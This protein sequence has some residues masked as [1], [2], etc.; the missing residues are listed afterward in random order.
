[1]NR[2]AITCNQRGFTLLEI[3][4]VLGIMVMLAGML[5]PA[6]GLMNE[7]ERERITRARMEEIRRAIVGD[8][9]RVDENGRRIIGGYVGD[10]KTWPDLYEAAPEKRQNV[11][12]TP[13]FD[14]NDPN[15]PTY[16][17]YRPSGRF[18][19]KNWRWNFPYH[20]LTDD[21]IYNNDHIGGLVTENEGQPVGL[22]SDNPK[23]DGTEM[24][25]H[26]RWQ[27]PYL[28]PPADNKPEDSLHL[29]ESNGDY[30][31][32]EPKYDP[33]LSA[34][35][36]E[37]G[38][39]SPYDFD[40]GEHFDEKEDFRLRQT[41]ERLADGW[42][43][44]FRFYITADPARPGET[45]FW[46]VSEGADSEGTYPTKGN[47]GATGWTGDANDTM[48][49]NYDPGDEYNRDNLVMK[50]YSHEWRGIFAEQ[51][52]LARQLTEAVFTRIRRALVGESTPS[53]SGFNNG[54]TGALCRLPRLFRWESATS[55]WDDHNDEATP[56]AYTKGQPRGLWTDAPNSAD[57]ADDLAEPSSASMGIGWNRN[58]IVSPL[59]GGENAILT[60]GWEREILFF[61]DSGG[62]RMM[63]LSRGADAMF[64]FYDTDT[65]PAGAPDGT[66]D[67]LE[68]ASPTELLDISTYTANDAGGY[69]ADNVVM[70]IKTNSWKPAWFTLEKLT[71]LNA[72]SGA[73]GTKACFFYSYDWTTG[74]PLVKL[75]TAAPLL[76]D[77]D[78]DGFSDDWT[79]GGTAPQ[80]AFRFDNTTTDSAVTGT[81]QLVIWNDANGNNLVDS[82][83]GHYPVNYNLVTH[84]GLE[85]RD[86]LVIDTALHFTVVP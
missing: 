68:P 44:A 81:R 74:V 11:V 28:V 35:T 85:P 17:Y 6:A 2:T 30:E 69:N 14:V 63:V 65:L 77:E 7:R 31:L 36:W 48:A 33:G 3:L 86:E 43:R 80:Q 32:L 70:V 49:V 13:V 9:D 12:G 47:C 34:E 23:G 58:F 61:H 19:G 15:N 66:P 76:T 53:D 20:K 40:L 84:N 29:A 22:W 82:G 59:A 38:D 21:I 51:D 46:I 42:N 26:E 16:F 60:D 18:I 67:Y 8:P 24:L 5:Y 78:G 39:Y 50:I 45:I 27:G 37:D 73:N 56:I 71:V 1:M 79:V 83:E 72:T 4:V 54:F 75:L 41:N 10:M 62:D 64:D 55:S 52:I 25:D 57:N